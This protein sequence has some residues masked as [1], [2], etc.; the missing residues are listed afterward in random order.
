MSISIERR[1]AGN[2]D[3]DYSELR[4]RLEQ[5]SRVVAYIDLFSRC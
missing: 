1:I 5:P 4:A 3:W 2:S